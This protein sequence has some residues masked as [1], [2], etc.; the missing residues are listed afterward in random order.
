MLRQQRE[1]QR[2]QFNEELALKKLQLGQEEGLNRQRAALYESQAGLAKRKT[3]EIDEESMM[4]NDLGQTIEQLVATRMG[5]QQN[6]NSPADDSQLKS[7]AAGQGARLAASGKR[8]VP[9]NIAQ[10]LDMMTPEGQRMLSTGTKPLQSLPAGNISLDVVDG[11]PKVYSPRT[12]S[13]GQ[14]L[15]PGEGGEAIAQGLPP[16]QNI[17]VN[18]MTEQ[19]RMIGSLGNI[20]RNYDPTDLMATKD[21]TYQA[22]TNALVPLLQNLPNLMK[23]AQAPIPTNLP[24]EQAARQEA[25]QAIQKRPDKADAI[26]QR[27]QQMYKKDL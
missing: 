12:L 20:V 13:Q 17:P 3:A 19:Q 5:M 26:R 9:Q 8:F 10:I 4:E 27:F 25:L 11:I 6:P 1:E 2:R 24:P 23:G 14:V 15:V 18:P 16:R 22:A 21:P 7:R